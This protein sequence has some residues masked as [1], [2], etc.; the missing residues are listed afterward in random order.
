LSIAIFLGYNFNELMSIIISGRHFKETP[1]LEKYTQA[2]I[3]KFYRHHKEILKIEVVMDSETARR[4]KESD[5]IVEINVHVPG[6]IFEVKDSER[7]M[8][9][10]VDYATDKMVRIL[11]KDKEKHQRR[12]KIAASS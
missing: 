1:A 6:H 10:A 4:G 11:T 5:F 3:A 7:D 8:Y 2:K 9:K 12:R